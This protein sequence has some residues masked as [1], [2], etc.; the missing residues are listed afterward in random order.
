[1][2]HLWGPLASADDVIS[3]VTQGYSRFATTNLAYPGLRCITPSAFVLP[4]EQYSENKANL[5]PPCLLRHLDRGKKT[6]HL[7]RPCLSAFTALI[8][9]KVHPKGEGVKVGQSKF[10]FD[11]R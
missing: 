5:I 2:P 8:S 3:V 7:K 9:Q 10:L 1:M 11:I 6:I 4:T